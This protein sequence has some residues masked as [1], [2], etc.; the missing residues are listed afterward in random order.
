M[1]YV[2]YTTKDAAQYRHR[3][4]TSDAR[5]S[6]FIGATDEYV[7][8]INHPT[9]E[10]AAIPILVEEPIYYQGIPT[11]RLDYAVFFTLM[12]IAGAVEELTPDWFPEPELI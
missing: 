5:A 7:P 8:V 12:E 2:I 9:E 1:Q 11:K 6:G 4:L 10:K 3:L